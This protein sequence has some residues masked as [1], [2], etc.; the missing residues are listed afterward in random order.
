MLAR[1]KRV[2]LPRWR[3]DWPHAWLAPVL[4]AAC[5]ALAL[6]SSTELATQ[7][8]LVFIG[9][10]LVLL[11]GLHARLTEYLHGRA[12]ERLAPLPIA[13]GR[14]FS[15][16]LQAHRRGLV[17]AVAVAMYFV[18]NW[19][20]KPIKLVGESMAEIAKGRFDHR[21]AE[22]R[23]DEFGQLYEVFDAMAA[24]LQDRQSLSPNDT[25]GSVTTTTQIT[26][27]K[28]ATVVTKASPDSTEAKPPAA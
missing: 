22:R 15:A 25:Y 26:S 7:R 1:V 17:L 5:W 27:Y 8:S 10:P 14:H 9:G 18:A 12:R 6:G 4:A 2:P 24:A 3:A 19:F 21:I 28:P 20:A 13:P 11:A 23:K 16:G